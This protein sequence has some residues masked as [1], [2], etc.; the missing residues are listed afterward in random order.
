MIVD[1]HTDMAIDTVHFSIQRELLGDLVECSRTGKSIKLRTVA[2]TYLLGLQT[3]CNEISDQNDL[4]PEGPECP[5][6]TADMKPCPDC[7]Y[8]T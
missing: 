3:L 1:T 4:D 7:E 6:C 2:L 5:G 8:P